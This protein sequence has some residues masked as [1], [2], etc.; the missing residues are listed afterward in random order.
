MRFVA[1]GVLLA[2]AWPSSAVALRKSQETRDPS[3]LAAALRG[4]LEERAATDESDP[5]RRLA[6]AL[7]PHG[8]TSLR[9]DFDIPQDPALLNQVTRWLNA[10]S[11]ADIQQA[12]ERVGQRHTVPLGWGVELGPTERAGEAFVGVPPAGADKPWQEYEAGQNN[13]MQEFLS[14]LHEVQ[15]TKVWLNARGI[16]Y[17][18]LEQGRAELH[19]LTLPEGLRTFLED[20]D[21]ELALVIRHDDLEAWNDLRWLFDPRSARR[22]IPVRVVIVRSPE[23]QR[24]IVFGP[25]GALAHLQGYYTRA[26]NGRLPAQFTVLSTEY[27]VKAPAVLHDHA[28]RLDWEGPSGE[29][30][31]RVEL[32][33]FPKRHM[34]RHLVEFLAEHQIGTI[35]LLGGGPL[36]L[37]TGAGT[38]DLDIVPLVP[39]AQAQG[40]EGI[41]EDS[42]EW[43][44]FLTALTPVVVAMQRGKLMTQPDREA[45]LMAL[46]QGKVLFEDVPLAAR[47]MCMVE[48]TGG[49]ARSD[50]M[51]ARLTIETL[52]LC[53][54]LRQR[55]SA[56]LY[57]PYGGVEDLL[58]GHPRIIGYRSLLGRIDPAHGGIQGPLH[59]FFQILRRMIS[60]RLEIGW[61]PEVPDQSVDQLLH[62]T[63]ATW[64]ERLE[65][66]PPTPGDLAIVRTELTRFFQHIPS[67]SEGEQL[68]VEFGLLDGPTGHLATQP[69]LSRWYGLT[70]EQVDQL[71]DEVARA[72][73]VSDS[74]DP[75][76]VW[77]RLRAFLTSNRL[78]PTEVGWFE[79]P[80]RDYQQRRS[81]I[82]SPLQARAGYPGRSFV[83]A[84]LP[85][86]TPPS[87]PVLRVAVPRLL[88]RYFAAEH[89]RTLV[90]ED[91]WAKS[92]HENDQHPDIAVVMIRLDNA[93]LQLMPDGSTVTEDDAAR[94]TTAMQA[95]LKDYTAASPAA[96][97]LEEGGRATVASLREALAQRGLVLDLNSAEVVRVVSDPA[98]W[99]PLRRWQQHLAQWDEAI[100]ALTRGAEV[101]I[102]WHLVAL[103]PAASAA[104]MAAPGGPVRLIVPRADS[105]EPFG[106]YRALAEQL[107]RRAARAGPN[108]TRWLTAADRALPEG[109][110]Q[111]LDDR[112][113][114]LA[115]RLDDPS[116]W[117][118]LP[119]LLDPRM[120]ILA[121][122]ARGVV[123]T[124]DNPQ[125][126]VDSARPTLNR[127]RGYWAGPSHF[128]VLSERYWRR[129]LESFPSMDLACKWYSPLMALE[130]AKTHHGAVVVFPPDHL[131]G[132]DDWFPTIHLYVMTRHGT[133]RDGSHQW[134]WEEA[135]RE[136]ADARPGL[137][138]EGHPVLGL[139]E[140]PALLIREIGTAPPDAFPGPALVLDTVDELKPYTAADLRRLA[141]ASDL[142]GLTV[143][144][145]VVFEDEHQRRRLAAFL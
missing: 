36:S 85:Y 37:L 47:P 56:W 60:H 7:Q 99:K 128:V 20:R 90:P 5:L 17:H 96:T 76:D 125:Y 139:L 75:T 110:R 124:A 26:H 107:P 119:W 89:D 136:V 65:G 32:K 69:F 1:L 11:P 111:V 144:A 50:L 131:A 78:H 6:E 101:P 8:I 33:A 104:R 115:L 117:A 72:Q 81:L 134:V 95:I 64:N 140:G 51:P 88:E 113:V 102:E 130:A 109:L 132:S 61:R 83:V 68:L 127:L 70:R 34:A 80:F 41:G 21:V 53:P 24:T 9:W 137:V 62:G 63:L 74:D 84:L 35:G 38:D 58:A 10:S 42:E 25:R 91:I 52:V 87:G 31:Y 100:A 55:T 121:V 66:R 129:D 92:F 40:F 108:D 2:L 23:D 118:Q 16:F 12:A 142:K 82:L 106:P 59:R 49:P 93:Q 54:N 27:W 138:V 120:F 126:L 77:G 98:L 39:R 135:V 14:R 30:R 123:G 112:G 67:V 48:E 116:G 4:G 22:S 45:A 15:A 71:V 114:A 141:M 18:N 43:Q 143:R 103:A 3:T 122:P 28:L 13:W 46:V 44:R 97:G 73:R 57:D 79:Q 19:K 145:L 86:Q 29:R 133:P 94:M 105:R